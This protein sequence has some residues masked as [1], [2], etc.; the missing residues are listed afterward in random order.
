[1]RRA[2]GEAVHRQFYGFSEEPFSI[3]PDTGFWY[4]SRNHLEVLTTIRAGIK[5]GKGILVITGEDGMGKTILLRLLVEMLDPGVKA[6]LI[7]GPS[8]SFEVVLE[9]LLRALELPRGEPDK[10]SMLSRLYE[11]LYSGLSR[12][13]TV[14]IAVDEAHAFSGQ[15]L[16]ELRMLC[17]PDPRRPGPGI[18]QEL[19]AAGPEFEEKLRA[20]DLMRILQRIE[21]RCRLGPLSEL[22]I[23]QYV[24]HRLRKV[25]SGIAKIFTPEAVD[26]ICKYSRGIPRNINMLCYMSICS[27]YALSRKHISSDLVEKALPVLN[28]HRSGRWQG[29]AGPVKALDDYIEKSPF[30]TTITYILLAYSLLALFIVFLLNLRL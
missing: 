21:V 22:E 12:G 16:E 10:S 11:Y 18:V 27:G 25:G 20:E 2:K 26:L 6:A 1:M 3:K 7:S 30:I 17:N 9:D 14:L 29:V 4:P 8:E 23:P 13:Q 24:E 19:F 28:G 5:S 15:V